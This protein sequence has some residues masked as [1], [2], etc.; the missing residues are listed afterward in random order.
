MKVLK[1]LFAR[2]WTISDGE[3]VLSE[4]LTQRAAR[5]QARRIVKTTNNI[6]YVKKRY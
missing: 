3:N 4:R 1:K 6:H 5:R 2:K